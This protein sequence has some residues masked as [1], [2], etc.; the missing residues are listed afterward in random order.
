MPLGRGQ[1]LLQRELQRHKV[2]ET[3]SAEALMAVG[4]QDHVPSPSS[5]ELLLMAARTRLDGEVGDGGE[6]LA[7][8]VVVANGDQ[9]LE[10]ECAIREPL[11]WHEP[12]RQH[13]LQSAADE[14]FAAGQGEALAQ[15]EVEAAVEQQML[16][17]GDEYWGSEMAK[18]ALQLRGVP[19]LF[20]DPQCQEVL[21]LVQMKTQS[22][23]VCCP[24]A[25]C[26][27]ESFQRAAGFD[28]R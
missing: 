23:G 1:A 3:S 17:P 2:G 18:N 9:Q 20:A 10:N 16:M 14:Y 11:P 5:L 15:A 28:S 27:S 26:S 12:D 7:V 13:V 19:A 22:V 21:D 4:F 25:G 6:D 24:S 8:E